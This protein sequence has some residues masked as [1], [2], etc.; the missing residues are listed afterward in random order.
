M[1]KLIAD[2]LTKL[3][4]LKQDGVITS[5]EFEEQKKKLLYD[6]DKEFENENENEFDQNEDD[7]Y[8]EIRPSKR[9]TAGIFA[10]LLGTFGVHRFYMGYTGLGILYLLFCWTGIPTILGLIEGIIYLT[11]SD[12]EFDF[13]KDRTYPDFEENESNG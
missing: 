11:I 5:K 2:E 1:S 13:E 3:N 7:E 12:E 8:Y 10:L 6:N 4:K 9:T